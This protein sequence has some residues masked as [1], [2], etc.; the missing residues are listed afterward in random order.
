LF[1]EYAYF[2]FYS[3]VRTSYIRRVAA[4]SKSG[5]APVLSTAAELM[6]GAI[7]GAL[8]QIFTIPVSVIATRQQ[9]GHSL[10]KANKRNRVQPTLA[11]KAQA[12]E[13]KTYA[14]AVEPSVPAIKPSSS[15]TDEDDDYNDSFLDVAREIIREEGVTGLWLGLKPGLVLTVN[16]AITYGMF[17]RLKNAVL[18]AQGKGSDAK[19]GPWLAF[20][21][22]AMSKTMATVV[23][24][25]LCCCDRRLS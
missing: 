18:A 11:E 10:N 13:T 14:Q 25:L 19:L 7:A 22:G 15:A 17:E 20:V 6:L 16:P 8:A 2:F 12:G 5:K 3:F 4:R 21:V 9:I 24:T 1:P 23:C